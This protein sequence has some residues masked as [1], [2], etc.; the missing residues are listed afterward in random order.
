M[1]KHIVMFKLKEKDAE[2]M[3]AVVS[4]MRGLDGKKRISEIYRGWS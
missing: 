3:E 1:V 2:I 4:T